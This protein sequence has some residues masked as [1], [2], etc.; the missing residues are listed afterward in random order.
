LCWNTPRFTICS[1]ISISGGKKLMARG[2]GQADA[3]ARQA[4][5]RDRRRRGTTAKPVLHEPQTERDKGFL[6][7]PFWDDVFSAYYDPTLRTCCQIR[8]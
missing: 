7:D 4:S 8:Y 1:R 2:T 5:K 3:P 6:F